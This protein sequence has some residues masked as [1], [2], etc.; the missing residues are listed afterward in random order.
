MTDKILADV[1]DGI[2]WLTINNPERHNAVSIEMGQAGAE[3]MA[4]FSANTSVRVIVIRATGEKA[5]MSGGDIGDFTPKPGDAPRP[6]DGF[7]FYNSVYECA[8]PVV[9]ALKGYTMGGGVALAC[10][11]DLRIVATNSVFAIPAGKLGIAYPPHFLRWV[12][13]TIG[14]ANTKEM[15][16][17]GRRY[18]SDEAL[19]MGLV[20]C[21]VQPEA[22][23][24]TVLEYAQSIV[25]N[26][27]LSIRANKETMRHVV[28]DPSRWDK[29]RI[30]EL[31][32]ICKNSSDFA[33]G[34]R[35][36]AEKRKPVF[37]GE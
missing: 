26:A 2:G 6:T 22:L 31:N 25:D 10:A 8:K 17:T 28:Q 16:F 5:W 24:H 21:L 27:P 11:C 3:I 13:D 36:F 30:A 14:L 1:Q 37:R 20:N 19:R 23:V 18:N 32:S 34:R 4:R 15:L 35:A 9:A 33:E 7:A 12:I 29:S